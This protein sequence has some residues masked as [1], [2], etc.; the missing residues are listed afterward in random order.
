MNPDDAIRHVVIV[1][2]GTAGWMAAAALSRL[3]RDGRTQI[4]LVESEEIGTVGVGEAT[5]PPIVGF[6]SL[7]GIDEHDF[8]RHT[9]GTFKLGIE[10]VDWT[11]IGHR[12]IHPFGPI[13]ADIEAV[14][15]HQFW[16]KLWE[17][18]Q[19][20]WIED[21]NVSAV[22]AR[23]GRFAHPAAARA[24]LSGV[25]YA[26]HFDATLY[27]RYLRA[28][29]E[30]H[31]VER[32]EGKVVDVALRGEDGFIAAIALE[33][34]RRVEG[35]LFIDC[36][37][38]RGLL[39]E[40]ALKTGYED[41]TNWLPCDRAVAVQCEGAGNP[42]PYTRATAR[43][44][45][46]QWRIPLQHRVGTGYVFSSAHIDEDHATEVLMSNLESKALIEPRVLRFTSGIRRKAWNKNCLALGLSGG[47]MEPLESTS[48]H[49]VQAGITKLLALYPDRRFDPLEIDEY[50]R[51]TRLQWEQIRNFLVFH[52]HVVEREDSQFWRDRR[53]LAIPDE[54]ARKIALFRGRGRLFPNEFDLFQESSWIA[55]LLGQGAIPEHWDPLVDAISEGAVRHNLELMRAHIRRIVEAMPT[56]A[57]YISANCGSGTATANTPVRAKA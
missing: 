5:I 20:P 36:T 39:I 35:D 11:R 10:Y 29:A 6:N 14:K 27:A 45:G 31:G 16:R 41:W 46:W 38:F 52:Y 22:A 55:V 34:D 12:Y 18:G 44:A 25:T 4:T 53:A 26:Y 56:H 3:K 30:S 8:L 17:H 37:G 7:L 43:D 42:T 40:D 51:L 54:L 47:F 32:L 33:G 19:T 48:I 2:G 24:P 28:Y 9:Q 21:Y 50:N 13:G 15:F 49:L 1:G 57:E 23:L